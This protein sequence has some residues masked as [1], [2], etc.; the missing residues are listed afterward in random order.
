[1]LTQRNWIQKY[2]N[3]D[4]YNIIN[5]P[6][7]GDCFFYAVALAQDAAIS[8]ETS[9]GQNSSTANKVFQN[10]T[11]R[12]SNKEIWANLQK[13]YIKN[14]RKQISANARF[15]QIAFQYCNKVFEQLELTDERRNEI[16]GQFDQIEGEINDLTSNIS[17]AQDEDTKQ[18]LQRAIDNLIQER[19][20]VRGCTIDAIQNLFNDE[21]VIWADELT[22]PIL[23]NLIKKK[24]IILNGETYDQLSEQGQNV[25]YE[26]S[27]EVFECSQFM[28]N[29]GNKFQDF[30][31]LA[32]NSGHYDLVSYTEITRRQSEMCGLFQNPAIIGGTKQRCV[33]PKE[34]AQLTVNCFNTSNKGRKNTAPLG[35]FADTSELNKID[36]E[37][38]SEQGEPDEDYF[39]TDLGGFTDTLTK[40]PNTNNS[41]LCKN[42]VPDDTVLSNFTGDNILN[43]LKKTIGNIAKK[44]EANK[45]WVKQNAAQL[46]SDAR[47]FK[48]I[49]LFPVVK[50]NPTSKNTNKPATNQPI[51]ASSKQENTQSTSQTDSLKIDLKNCKR[52][53][54]DDI[55]AQQTDT[56]LNQIGNNPDDIDKFFLKFYTNVINDC[57]N[58]YNH[59]KLKILN[60]IY[61]QIKSN[62]NLIIQ[63]KQNLTPEN[64][65]KLQKIQGDLKILLNQILK[66]FNDLNYSTKLLINQYFKQYI[67]NNSGSNTLGGNR[68]KTRRKKYYFKQSRKKYR[69]NKFNKIN[70]NKHTNKNIIY[71]S[72]QTTRKFS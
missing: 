18:E 52:Y 40:Q 35:V 9:Q 65:I 47:E 23:E 63:L 43:M 27:P 69:I 4:S 29:D 28:M 53:K 46:V 34:V 20:N 64:Q 31:I 58:N 2:L 10:T 5:V 26:S 71:K 37:L 11:N 30:I 51:N 68:S 59:D 41:Q 1:M 12:V 72:R 45:Q 6:G 17:Q 16:Q 32:Y 22:I 50:N 36:E 66:K 42:P 8:R 67:V 3:S 49:D 14:W 60:D 13:N 56:I 70:R 48:T 55:I 57:I 7:D 33:L 44:E 61:P 38:Q 24:C 25:T 39:Q 62:I 19:N 21:A 15:S 54:G